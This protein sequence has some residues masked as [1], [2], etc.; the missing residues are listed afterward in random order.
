LNNTKGTV[1]NFC[2]E[3]TKIK[4][5]VTLEKNRNAKSLYIIKLTIA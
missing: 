5:V 4:N 3:K 1:G 2:L